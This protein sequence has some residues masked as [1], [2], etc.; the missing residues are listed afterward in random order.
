MHLSKYCSVFKFYFSLHKYFY[1]LQIILDSDEQKEA[2]EKSTKN[3]EEEEEEKEGKGAKANLDDA[4][5]KITNPKE[6]LKKAKV[7]D[8]E[9]KE[10]IV[11]E[12]NYYS[13]AH[14]IREEVHEQPAILVNGRLKE[15][16]VKVN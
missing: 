4:A 2:Q 12:K 13:I 7:E 15:Y 16:Q 10:V 9:Y 3:E 8:D 11:G 5:E 1:L 14:T 6:I